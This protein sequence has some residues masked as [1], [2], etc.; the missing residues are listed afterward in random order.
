MGNM[1]ILFVGYTMAIIGNFLV[2]DNNLK[3]RL[4]GFVICL[5]SCVV[6]LIQT[7]FVEPSNLF[8]LFMIYSI[9][10]IIGILNTRK[11]L[12]GT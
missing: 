1:F 3:C 10:N 11:Q 7:V 2:T 8:G 4:S 9:I 6:F 12:L 5:I